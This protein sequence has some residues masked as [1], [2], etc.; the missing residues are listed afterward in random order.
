M[1]TITVEDG[2]R[3]TGA[4]SYVSIEELQEYANLRG[5]TIA[6]DVIDGPVPTTAYTNTD[7]QG[8]RTGSIAVTSN[9]TPV[10]GDFNNII[11]GNAA[12]NSTH[13]VEMP[14]TIN[15]ND[16]ILL[17]FGAG[18]HVY[19]TELSV[20]GSVGLDLEH[21]KVEVSETSV[22]AED[23]VT[24]DASLHILEGA[25]L[26]TFTFPSTFGYR[27]LKFTKIDSSLAVAGGTFLSELEFKIAEGPD[28]ISQGTATRLIIQSMDYVEALPFKGTKLTKEQPLQWP[29]AYVVIDGYYVDTDEIPQQLKDAQMEAAISINAGTGPLAD[30]T[31]TQKRVKV[32]D[33]EVEY[34]D[35]ANSTTLV[36]SLTNK[37]TKLL[38]GGGGGSLVVKRG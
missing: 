11:N 30:I 32:G 18:E 9:M 14:A 27:Y 37:L 24:V 38:D 6:D 25:P 36:R 20:Y 5:S 13:A 3:V 21:W 22:E 12:T 33:L 4:N 15:V 19:I 34:S 23:F 35:N 16:Y 7:G 1:A 26:A 29:R 8:D 10:S 2:S 31:R 17:D 28:R